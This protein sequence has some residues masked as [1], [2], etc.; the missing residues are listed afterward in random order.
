[1][2]MFSRDLGQNPQINM[3]VMEVMCGETSTSRPVSRPTRT[4]ASAADVG[5]LQESDLKGRQVRGAPF[6]LLF[7]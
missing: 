3:F 1:M 4:P 7:K 2:S 5:Y 6:S